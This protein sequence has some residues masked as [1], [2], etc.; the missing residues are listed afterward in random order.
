M[1]DVKPITDFL[2]ELDEK[3]SLIALQNAFSHRSI[4]FFKTD[5]DERVLSATIDSFV[6]KKVILKLE[7][8]DIPITVNVEVSIKFNIHT[9]I[10][11]IK[12]PIKRHLGLAYF[13]L[14][15]KVIQLKRRKEGRYLVPKKYLQTAMIASH[16]IGKKLIPCVVLDI[17][18]SGMRLEVK[19]LVH[20][21]LKRDEVIKIQFQIHRR[22]EVQCDAVVRFF[23]NRLNHGTLLGVELSFTKD[24]Q[25]ERVAG[26]VEDII[27]F[28]NGQKF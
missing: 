22:A 28:Q 23:M 19:D 27:S 3:E 21:Q 26:I 13:E 6:D 15:S 7:N 12:V 8:L 16:S 24:V 17:S 2:N 20:Y 5:A 10:Y 25:R 1:S 4:L 9:E 18:Y 11:F 14:S